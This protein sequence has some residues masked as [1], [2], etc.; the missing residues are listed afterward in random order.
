MA[1]GSN[2]YV[3]IQDTVR[4]P[5][6][7]QPSKSGVQISLDPVKMLPSAPLQRLSEEDILVPRAAEAPTKKIF[8][9]KKAP[10]NTGV[11]ND[12]TQHLLLNPDLALAQITVQP[13]GVILPSH[14]LRYHSN[15]W[16]TFLFLLTLVILA[17]VKSSTKK[18]FTLLVQSVGSF[19]AS[20]RMYREQ[21]ISLV[22]GSSAMEVFY[23]IVMA[24]FGYQLFQFFG[25]EFPL[26]D[27]LIFLIILSA[28]FVFIQ[29]KYLIYKLL[30]FFN[31][32]S[33]DTREYLFN[34]QN[35]H[36]M[37][38]LLLWPIVVA[39]AWLPIE[40]SRIFMYSGLI[41]TALINLLYLIRGARILIKKHYSFFYLFL[42]LCTLEI[43]PLLLF[44]KV[45][46]T[47]SV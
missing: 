6:P 9:R 29:T 26:H 11:L 37:L 14:P 47:S 40:D 30:A 24:L 25:I 2:Y 38:G 22:Q 31:E 19:Q 39:I 5:V 15:D 36:R 13:A 20:T 45:L 35:Y 4:T 10:E 23:L 33:A 41:L 18:Y 42:Y 3:I 46:Q 43:L 12:T 44:L 21:N 27:V 28:I 17:L 32:T 1:S 8:F 16:F 7:A 34:I